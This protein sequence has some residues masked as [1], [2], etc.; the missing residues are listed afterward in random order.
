[1]DSRGG[2]H[3]KTEAIQERQ[4][5]T[6]ICVIN[7][8]AAN[9]PVPTKEQF[10][11]M[12]DKN[13]HGAGIMVDL[14]DGRVYYKKGMMTFGDFMDTYDEVSRKYDLTKQACAFHFRIKTHG[15][16]NAETTHPFILSPRYQDLRQ[17]EYI[18]KT[19]VM[20]HN[21]TIPKFGGWLDAKSSDTQ[22]FAATI[23]Y[24]MMRKSKKGRKPSKTMLKAADALLGGSRIIV[25]YGD[26]KPVKL[27]DWPEAEGLCTSNSLWTS[28]Y[29]QSALSSPS[30]SSSSFYS[31]PK[32]DEFGMWTDAYPS[33]GR[34]WI[35]YSSQTEMD[36]YTRNL[37]KVIRNG[38]TYIKPYSSINEKDQYIIDGLEIYNAKG[39]EKRIEQEAFYDK[40]EEPQGI[41]EQD[42]IGAS[43][44]QELYS[45]LM[46]LTYD[47]ERA[48]YLN[49]EG[50]AMYV[51]YHSLEAWSE[52]ALDLIYGKA[53]RY[54]KR[55][56]MINGTM[57]EKWE[58]PTSDMKER[59]KAKTL[60]VIQNPSA[61]TPGDKLAE[62]FMTC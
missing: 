62:E 17:L 14:G 13:P 30:S 33:N 26:N 41:Q 31:Q 38:H 45:E 44:A 12:W 9:K 60:S 20:M 49:S 6:I 27:G 3:S 21:G 16:T 39:M 37:T 47:S 42:Y 46:E 35:Q 48:V 51:D 1:M 56:L 15:E 8:S 59:L 55:D 54:A 4:T 28:S 32:Q 5:V 34:D 36:K 53:A 7:F 23:G 58:K 40:M 57:T 2:H 25:F 24:T 52:K 10:Q 29:T 11:K 50:D 22:D 61:K 43:D 19:P 18:G